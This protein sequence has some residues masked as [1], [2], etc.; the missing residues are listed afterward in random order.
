M[1]YTYEQLKH[2]TVLNYV[3]LPKKMS[4]KH[5]RATRS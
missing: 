5:C 2:K 3:T 4:T 1:D